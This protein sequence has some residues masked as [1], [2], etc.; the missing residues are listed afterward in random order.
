MFNSLFQDRIGDASK[1]TGLAVVCV[2]LAI[3]FDVAFPSFLSSGNLSTIALNIAYTLIAALGSLMLLLSGNV[4]LSIGAI[5]AFTG[6]AVVVVGHATGSTVLP[7]VLGLTMGLF[8]GYINGVLVTRLSINPLVVTLAMNLVW[9]GLAYVLTDGYSAFGLPSRLV[10]IG[11]GSFVGLPIPAVIALVM[12]L[13]GVVYLRVSVFGLRVYAVGGN[14]RA[15]KLI[16]L[17]PDRVTRKIFAVNGLLIGCVAVL[18]AAQ[19]NSAT[20]ETGA[21]FALSVL[22]A[23]VLGGV[24]FTG[25]AGTGVGVF[26]GVLTIGVIDAGLVFSGTASWYQQI[27]EGAVLMIALGADQFL[28]HSRFSARGRRR[29]WLGSGSSPINESQETALKQIELRAGVEDVGCVQIDDALNSAIEANVVRGQPEYSFVSQNGG[30]GRQL[31]VRQPVLEMF[32][33]SKAYGSVQAIQN[34]SFT[35]HAGEVI[36]LVGDNGAGKSTIVRI[37]AGADVPDAG[38]VVL[39]GRKL[40]YG[41]PARVRAMGL[42]TVFQDLALFDNLSVI[43]N[44]TLGR[45]VIK[46]GAVAR[47]I[48]LRNDQAGGRLALLQLAEIGAR[49][50]DLRESCRGLSGG[51]RQAVAI[52]RA[53]TNDARIILMDEPTA[54]LGVQQTAEVLRMIATVA[55]RGVAVIL[56]THDIETVYEIADTAVVLRLGK[57]VSYGPVR[58]LDRVRLLEMMAG[59]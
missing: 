31:E 15:A 49:I 30:L 3:G 47:A 14:S 24:A 4:D 16:G 27:T 22:T 41:D 58:Q 5:W 40:D 37:L 10:G 26:V 9:G 55:A 34:I 56:V 33:V 57:I 50:P 29:P 7:I 53:I 43:H 8:L 13:L 35:I 2:L 48:R 21:T 1:R 28:A 42:E 36:A 23:V 18:S 39:D 25:G 51:Q 44:L 46:R 54:A 52:A 17:H 19:L 20:P 45:E 38:Q 59:L 6:M 12:F 32:E 11:Q